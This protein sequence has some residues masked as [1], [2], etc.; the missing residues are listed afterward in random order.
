MSTDTN[1]NTN[2]STGT[3]TPVTNPHIAKDKRYTVSIGSFVSERA[4]LGRAKA[5][6]EAGFKAEVRDD[7]YNP[8]MEITAALM[9]IANAVI[10]LNGKLDDISEKLDKVATATSAKAAQAFEENKPKKDLGELIRRKR[11]RKNITMA[12]LAKRIGVTRST[13]TAWETGK[14]TPRKPALR[15]LCQELG[16]EDDELKNY[17]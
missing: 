16:I 5:C 10:D 11:D 3:N 8:E 9:I 7:L 1:T 12:E 15:V 6:T 17:V 4:A 14:N 2:A 13:I